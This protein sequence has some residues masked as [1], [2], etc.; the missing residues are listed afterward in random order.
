[1]FKGVLRKKRILTIS[2]VIL[3]IVLFIFIRNNN[4]NNNYNDDNYIEEQEV[5]EIKE[6]DIDVIE[7]RED[8]LVFS[9]SINDF[10]DSY[11]GYYW[12][13]KKSSPFSFLCKN[14]TV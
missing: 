14:C 5:V 4:E 7:N 1:M 12:K 13:D 11:N 8:E 3:I 9:F 6:L 10:I 2:L